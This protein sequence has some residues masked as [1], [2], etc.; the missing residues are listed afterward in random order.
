MTPEAFRDAFALG[1]EGLAGLPLGVAR[2]RYDRLCQAFA[3]PL[4][5]GMIVEDGTIGGVAV[6]RL[7]PP[8]ARPGEVA[9][10]H[11]GG[12]TLGSVTSHQGI[13]ASLAAHL[14]R[15][16]VSVDY[17]LAPEASYA[18]ALADC[19]SVIRALAPRAAVGD[20]AGGRLVMD[21]SH[22]LGAP[23]VLGLI[24]P[25]VGRPDPASLGPDAP[26]LS[27][28]EVLTLWAE[29][30]ETMPSVPEA[31]PPGRQLEV[32]AVAQDPLT[33][34]LERALG[35]WRRFGCDIGYRCVPG[36]WHGAL[37]AHAR[38]PAMQ[39]AWQVF[40][41]ALTDRLA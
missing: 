31:A 35:R 28:A 22:T 36:L 1:L 34:P 23:G 24:Y 6:R 21:V 2:P 41:A 19:R 30:A 17:R 20:S 4:P 18:D 7:R 15:E 25:L 13:A 32:L 12:W 10:V 14:K 29:V 5:A 11:G 33:A 8:G 40:C 38:L 39:E 3:P 16:V 37:H 9:Y 27:R 26:L